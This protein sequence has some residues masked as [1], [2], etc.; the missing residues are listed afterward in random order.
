MNRFIQKL[1]YTAFSFFILYCAVWYGWGVYAK[2]ILHDLFNSSGKYEITT[3]KIELSGFPFN[4]SYTLRNLSVSEKNE[5]IKSTINLGNPVLKSD[6]LLGNFVLEINDNIT[7]SSSNNK[8]NYVL[9][10]NKGASISAGLKNSIGYDLIKGNTKP[11]SA[12]DISKIEYVDNGYSIKDT[13]LEKVI[14][15]SSKNNFD[16]K[17]TSDHL[18]DLNLIVAN[19]N[20][21]GSE[22]FCIQGPLNLNANFS[23]KTILDEKNLNKQVK[24]LVFNFSQFILA[25]QDYS[26]N[27]SGDLNVMGS[28][29]DSTGTVLVKLNNVPKFLNTVEQFYSP[30]QTEYVKGIIYKM[31]GV[32]I[33][34]PLEN[35]DIEIKGENKDIKFGHATM[36]DL[37][38]YSLSK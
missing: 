33:D 6:F 29:K 26:L 18:S 23:I 10:Y 12:R 9:S 16:L 1:I 37:M 2:K 30:K 17:V 7:I 8:H 25:V 11:L 20:G 3:D 4:L 15:N 36:V 32:E 35:M 5:D 24:G 22:G 31:S 19:F 13:I 34:Q 27:I 28:D 14:F 38:L 21:E